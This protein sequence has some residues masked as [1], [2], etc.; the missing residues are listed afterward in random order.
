MRAKQ[1]TRVLPGYR[2]KRK[3]AEKKAGKAG[4]INFSETKAVR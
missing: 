1:N 2:F 4:L 3:V